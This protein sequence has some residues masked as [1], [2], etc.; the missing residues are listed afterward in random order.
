MSEDERE[1]ASQRFLWLDISDVLPLFLSCE[2]DRLP[3]CILE[4]VFRYVNKGNAVT[5]RAWPA[6][7]EHR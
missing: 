1:F 4:L 2:Y 6:S 5:L 3:Y 7:L